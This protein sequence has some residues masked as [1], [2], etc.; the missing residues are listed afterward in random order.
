VNGT[1]VDDDAGHLRRLK[2]ELPGEA[3]L[4]CPDLVRLFDLGQHDGR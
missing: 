4:H 3:E 1:A 2:Q